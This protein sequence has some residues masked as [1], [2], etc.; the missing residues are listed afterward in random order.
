MKMKRLSCV[1]LFIGCLI[2]FSA[3][4]VGATVTWATGV[5]ETSGW[6]DAEKDSVNQDDDNLCWAASASNILKWS[7]WDAG[8]AS[9]DAIFNFLEAETP[10]DAGGWWSQAWDFW[11]SGYWEA[12]DHFDGSDHPGYYSYNEYVSNSI[13]Q[14]DVGETFMSDIENLFL[15][16]YGVGVRIIADAEDGINHAVTAWGVEM[17]AGVFTGIY[18]TD[19]DD[20]KYGEDPRANEL[21]L[22]DVELLNGKWYLTDYTNETC[23]LDVYQALKMKAVPL[24]SSVF[25][26]IQGVLGVAFLS[27]RGS[28]KKN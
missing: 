13:V 1:I 22:Y 3:A 26:L 2:V 18:L 27:R 24:P 12:G 10:L 28:C 4:S 5:S 6:Y 21:I 20:D 23:Y 14:W 19:S 17:E 8:Y 15:N 16:D 9:E 11:F 25:F 7:K